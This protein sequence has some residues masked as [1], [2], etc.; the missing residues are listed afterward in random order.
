MTSQKNVCVGGYTIC[1]LFK[2]ESIRILSNF[3]FQWTN[4]L[5]QNNFKHI[6]FFFILF[7]GN[8]CN[9]FR[10]EIKLSTIIMRIRYEI[11]PKKIFLWEP[12]RQTSKA[13]VN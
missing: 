3:N 2:T 9:K 1:Y 6:A 11:T 8:K 12:K 7:K 5:Y 13:S 4:T 10:Y